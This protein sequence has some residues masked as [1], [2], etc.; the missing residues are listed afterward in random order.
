MPE[1]SAYCGNV[2][3]HP[4]GGAVHI[5]KGSASRG[6]STSY[7]VD[8]NGPRKASIKGDEGSRLSTADTKPHLRPTILPWE[9]PTATSS[10]TMTKRTFS[11]SEGCLAAY[12][13]FARPKFR[14]SPV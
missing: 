13:S 10:A 1:T 2:F 14:I 11:A 6:E 12:C 7:L 3:A 8:Q 9:R 4:G 5:V